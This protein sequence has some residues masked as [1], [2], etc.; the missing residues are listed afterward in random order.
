[1]LLVPATLFAQERSAFERSALLED[2]AETAAENGDE[3]TDLS[4]VLEELEDSET[5]F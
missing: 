2:I 5:I 4:A 3:N 1:M